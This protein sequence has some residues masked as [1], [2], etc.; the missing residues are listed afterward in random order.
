M[1]HSVH[2]WP[3]VVVVFDL[4]GVI[5]NGC[6]AAGAG[7]CQRAH[8]DLS[9]ALVSTPSH[10]NGKSSHASAHERVFPL[11]GVQ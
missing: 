3:G 2:S 7:A 11:P 10:R 9:P 5:Y 6:G 4:S 1:C 8:T